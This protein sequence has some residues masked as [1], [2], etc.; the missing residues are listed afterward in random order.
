MNLFSD[1]ESNIRPVDQLQF[2]LMEVDSVGEENVG[3]R[4]LWPLLAAVA[5]VILII[6]WWF[7]HRGGIDLSRFRTEP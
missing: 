5:I 4:E 6:E 1:S 3:Q 2:G 7:Y